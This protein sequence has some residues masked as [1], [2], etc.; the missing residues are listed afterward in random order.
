MAKITITL[1]RTPAQE[2]KDHADRLVEELSIP[3]GGKCQCCGVV[4]HRRGMTF[5][6]YKYKKSEKSHR[7]FKGK[8]L[9]Y[10]QYLGPIIRRRKK[11][12]LYVCTPCHVF[13][14]MT[15]RMKDNRRIRKLMEAVLK[16][17]YLPP[18]RKS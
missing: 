17:E 12:F 13:I 10:Y 16:T 4:Y 11:G 9:E 5:H 6:H 1:K 2:R 15:R 8:R 18:R 14:T 7:D 3:F